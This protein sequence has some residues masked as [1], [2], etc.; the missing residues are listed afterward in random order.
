VIE[1]SNTRCVVGM[2]LVVAMNGKNKGVEGKGEGR[3]HCGVF[4]M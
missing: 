2:A 4:M 1:M 3:P